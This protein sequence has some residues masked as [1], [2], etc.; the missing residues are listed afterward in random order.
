M[1]IQWYKMFCKISHNMLNPHS[2]N[3]LNPY[4]QNMLNPHSHNMLNTYSKT[5]FVQIVETVVTIGTEPF[6]ITIV[7]S[8]WF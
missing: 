1:S 8:I 6:A 4:S 7:N 5:F 3:M 2:H